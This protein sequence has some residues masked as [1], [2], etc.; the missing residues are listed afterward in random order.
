MAG[1]LE[2]ADSPGDIAGRAANVECAR[3]CPCDK[4][5]KSPGRRAIDLIAAVGPR[6]SVDLL[7]AGFDEQLG[8]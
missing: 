2:P 8:D 7:D 1:E 3:D 6:G 4:A 5:G